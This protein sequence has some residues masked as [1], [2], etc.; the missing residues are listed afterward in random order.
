[1]SIRNN[2]KRP[3]RQS[4]LYAKLQTQS[5]VL[6]GFQ[7]ADAADENTSWCCHVIMHLFLVVGPHGDCRRNLEVNST[8][9]AHP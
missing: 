2:S 7:Q 1:M 3:Q 4:A 9:V 8:R 6:P 5:T